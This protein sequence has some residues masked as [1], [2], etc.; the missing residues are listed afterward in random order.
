MKLIPSKIKGKDGQYCY[1]FTDEAGSWVIAPRYISVKP[2]V[3]NIAFVEDDNCLWGVIDID[4]NWVVEPTF[5]HIWE[6]IDGIA[7]AADER[8]ESDLFNRIGYIDSKGNWLI[9]PQFYKATPFSNDVAMVMPHPGGKWGIIDKKGGWIVKPRYTKIALKV[10]SSS[11]QVETE[12]QFG[13]INPHGGWIVGPFFK[14]PEIKNGINPD[15]IILKGDCRHEEQTV[16]EGCRMDFTLTAGGVLTISGND[17]LCPVDDAEL[18]P[19]PVLEDET[20]IAFYPQSQFKHLDFNTIVVESGVKGFAP[21]SLS[22][23][24]NLPHLT[25]IIKH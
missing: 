25:L 5:G 20:D 1:G 15:E 23:C 24:K 18:S 16:N 17:Y 7:M 13:Q 12:E 21:D 8:T 10:G 19:N 9:S 22:G 4:G 3:D 6:F 11:F 14:M 2:F